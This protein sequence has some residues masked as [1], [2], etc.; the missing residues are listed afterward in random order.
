MPLYIVRFITS[1][2]LIEAEYDARTAD[3]C[4]DI[5]EAHFCE[6]RH[7][8]ELHEIVVMP[9]QGEHLLSEYLPREI[10]EIFRLTPAGKGFVDSCA[11]W[12]AVLH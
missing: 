2:T 8:G 10:Y 3:E 9:P 11:K 12:P 4:M 5:A 7:S 6:G 1:T